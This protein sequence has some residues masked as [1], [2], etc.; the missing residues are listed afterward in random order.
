MQRVGLSARRYIGVYSGFCLIKTEFGIC[1][2]LNSEVNMEKTDYSLAGW[3]AVVQAILFP[4]T[5]IWGLV[6]AG[7]AGR[8]TGMTRPFIGPSDLIMVAFTGIAVYTLLM[9][10]KL[11]NERYDYHELDLLILISVWWA[12]MFQMVGLGLGVIAMVY[13]PIDKIILA[14]VYLIFM[15]SAMVTIGIVDI[16]IAIKILKIKE[17]FGEFIRLFAYVTIVAGLCEV[18]VIFSP[19]SVVL[20]PVSAVILALIFFRDKYEVEFV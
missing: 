9:F 14:V 1:F 6:E 2:K 16:L 11:L 5:I 4:L 15:S 17:K 10:R 18:S 20:V 3:L 7:I 19:I 13:W 12:I 8:L